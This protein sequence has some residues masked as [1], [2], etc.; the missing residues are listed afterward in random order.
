MLKTIQTAERKMIPNGLMNVLSVLVL[1][2]VV[3]LKPAGA[4]V[5]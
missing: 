4:M 1:V 3:I 5:I 2:V